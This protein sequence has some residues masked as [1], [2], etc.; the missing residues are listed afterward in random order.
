LWLSALLCVSWLILPLASADASTIVQASTPAEI[1]NAILA[2]NGSGA[3]TEIHVAPGDY[4]FTQT[5]DSDDGLSHLPPITGTVLLIGEKPETTRFIGPTAARFI[6]VRQ[7]GSLQVTGLSLIGGSAVYDCNNPN[8]GPNPCLSHGGGAAL[9][10]GGVLWFENSVLSGNAAHQIMGHDGIG[11][12]ILSTGGDLHVSNTT[13]NG[14]A[15]IRTGAGIAVLGGTATLSH[16]IVSGNEPHPGNS[17]NSQVLWGYGIYIENA[18][19]SIDHSTV[20]G[21]TSTFSFEPFVVHGRGIFNSNGT[22]SITNSA[23]VE[24]TDQLTDPS[25]THLAG[26]GGGIYNGGAMSIADSTIAGNGAG[27]LGGGIANFGKL[28]LQSV[29]VAR[30]QVYGVSQEYM[31]GGDGISYPPDCLLVGEPPPPHLTGCFIGGGGIW[32]DPAA[33]TTVLST[34]VAL[35]TLSGSAPNG[36]FGPD[37][38]GP[39]I[40][41]GYNAIGVTTDCQLQNPAAGDQL[42]VDA[43]LGGLTDD[44]KPAHAHVPILSGSPLIDAGG[45]G[46]SVRDQIAAPRTDGDHD[47]VVECDVGAVEFGP[48]PDGFTLNVAQS[49]AGGTLRTSVG[50]WNFGNVTDALYGNNVLLNGGGTSGVATLL[51][52]SNGGKLY[53]QAGD[54]SWWLW[55][56]PGWSRTTE[57]LDPVS[58]DGS[59]L[60]VA[61]SQ[62]GGTLMTSAG[63]WNFGTTSGFYGNDVLLNGGGTSGVATLLEVA[64]SGKL[65]AQAGD[66]SWWLWNNPGW[67]SSAAPPSGGGGQVSPDGSTLTVAQSQGGGSLVTSAGKWTFGAVVTFYGNNVLLNGAGNGGYATLLEVANSGKL[68][69]QASDGSW[70]L[71]NNPG[72]SSSAAPP[73]GGG[74]VSPDGST[75]TVTQSQGGGSLVTSAGKW[76][77]GAVVTFYGNNVLLN[78]GGTS[79]YATLLEVANSGKLYAEASDGSWWLWNNP[80]W[81]RS[82]APTTGTTMITGVTFNAATN[83]REAIGSDNWPAAWSND[84]NQYAMWGDGG[85]FGGTDTDGRVSLGVARIE[86]DNTNYQGHN[87]YGGL[88]GECPA[89]IQGKSHGAPL[90]VGGILY[91]WITPG[92]GATGYDSFSLYRSMDYACTWTAVGVSF[93][94]T[95][96]LVSFG[97]FVQFGQDNSAAT[98][99]YVYSVAVAVTDNSSLAVVQRPGRVMLLRVPAASIASRAAY[100][101]YAGPDAGGQPSWSSDPAKAMPVYTDADG[102][103][104]FAQ[105]SYVPGL[106]RFVYT[107]QHGNGSDATGFES[108]LTMAEA[109]APWG[110]WTNFY[111]DVFFP[112]STL[113]IAQSQA[114]GTLTTSA[115]TWKFG[116]ASNAYGNNVLLNGGGTGGWATLLAVTSAQLYAQAGDG[117]WWRWNNPG[118]SA[119]AAPFE[120]TLFQWNFGPKWYRNGG[121]D[122]TLIFSG[123]N[124]NDS[125]N[126]IDGTFTTSP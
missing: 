33:T 82:S 1:V 15:S 100:Q 28:T 74:G 86:G 4:Q 115:G 118:W 105:M 26:A 85:G 56:N 87:R 9:N 37:C 31:F 102:V 90:S 14:N 13:V 116:A 96:D 16:S 52:V 69:A 104:P 36:V 18:N 109:P 99:T 122:F 30:N 79:G 25:R 29:T 92:A 91:A 20:S 63:T 64:N 84:G 77:F 66:S 70:W 107:N 98:D 58:P 71:W 119:A 40:S 94:R 5:F 117:S 12:A 47:G 55:N 45:T 73:S 10:A 80:G 34:V 35:N 39:M 42:G 89:T 120:Q 75:L 46:C 106:N 60:T 3:T 125:W 126:T 21:N 8:T 93:V 88:N 17:P 49:Q 54:G 41:N 61:Q 67:S 53:A 121:R 123:I 24:N 22:V 103:G 59:T 50:T 110:P 76:T 62:A 83:R 7:N 113:T 112:A 51:E 23:V 19:V 44:G 72:W 65:Y 2:A 78:G 43:T 6:N 57:P 114:G 101:F 11:G 32:T 48:T 108:L 68:Y 97:S 27:T 38:G 81:S 95:T 111:R 124:S